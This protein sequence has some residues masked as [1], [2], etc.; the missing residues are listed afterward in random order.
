MKYHVRQTIWCEIRHGNL[1]QDFVYHEFNE[2][3]FLIEYLRDPELTYW[4][5][6]LQGVKRYYNRGI[7]ETTKMQTYP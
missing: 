6:D 3:E 2:Q 1:V 5:E 7:L 4:T